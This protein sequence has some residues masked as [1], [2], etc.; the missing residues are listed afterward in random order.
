MEYAKVEISTIIKNCKNLV[1]LYNACE[2]LVYLINNQYQKKSLHVYVITA[3]RE[4][5]L[6]KLEK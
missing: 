5:E 2:C 1:Q 3:L 6:Q 4:K